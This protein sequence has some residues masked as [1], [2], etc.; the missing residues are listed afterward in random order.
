MPAA[1]DALARFEIELEML[2]EEISSRGLRI[3]ERGGMNLWR[4]ADGK[5]FIV[6]ERIVNPNPQQEEKFRVDVDGDE[7]RAELLAKLGDWK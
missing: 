2:S 6:F 5:N 1:I 4:D 3:A 7:S